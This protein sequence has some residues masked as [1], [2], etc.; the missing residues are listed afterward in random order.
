MKKQAHRKLHQGASGF[1]LVELLV[2]IAIIGVLIAL[3]LP[4]VQAA[5]ESARRSACQNNLRQVGLAIAG[6]ETSHRKF[7]PGKRWSARRTDPATFDY[8]WSSIILAYLEESALS[9][10]L[11][12]KQ[13][14]TSPSNNEAA[15]TIVPA[16]LCPSTAIIEE[17][18]SAEGRLFNLGG[19]PGEGLA[20][21]DYLGVSGPDKDKNNP[22]TG[23][24]YGPQ[25]GVLLGTK[26]LPDGDTLTEPPGVTAA[27]I[28]DGLSKTIDVVECSGRGVDLKKSGE[29]KSLN[30]AWASGS[31][32]SHIKK[33]VNEEA[34]PVAWEDERVYSQHTNGAQSL[35][36]DGS[37]RFLSINT[38]EA[39]LGALCSRDGGE[40]IDE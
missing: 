29:V 32:I 33:G 22:E 35:H 39:L 19:Q 2:V 6:Y 24:D 17:H 20:C 12:F 4:A 14:L 7:P 11:N 31:N 40:L 10:K 15:S 8:A 30:G 34:P 38:D 21:I 1:T 3:L 16:Y 18:R 26:G 23:V 36:C 37:V 25:R 9:V 27:R 5:R 13:P 28:T